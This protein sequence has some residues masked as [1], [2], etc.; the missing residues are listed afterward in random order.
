VA[1]DGDAEV[2]SVEEDIDGVPGFVALGQRLLRR[3]DADDGASDVVV[4]GVVKVMGELD[5]DPGLGGASLARGAENDVGFGPFGEPV[6]ESQ[7]DIFVF[8]RGVDPV[9]GAAGAGGGE[10][11]AGHVEGCAWP[12]VDPGAKGDRFGLRGDS[13][14]DESGEETKQA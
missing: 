2:V 9:G 12:F 6:I 14:D 11:A 4:Y 7:V 8:D 1:V 13:K 3:A 5:G 10:L